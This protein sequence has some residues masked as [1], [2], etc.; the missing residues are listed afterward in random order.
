MCKHICTVR[1]KG[2]ERAQKRELQFP[3]GCRRVKE[4]A[5]QEVT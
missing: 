3:F 5:I 1:S 2:S 4:D